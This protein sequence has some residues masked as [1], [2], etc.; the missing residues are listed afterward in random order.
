MSLNLSFDLDE[1]RAAAINESPRGKVLVI[2]AMLDEMLAEIL[3]QH[4]IGDMKDLLD[5]R[6]PFGSFGNK[7]SV[8]YAIGLIDEHTKTALKLI[9]NI[10]NDAAH[11]EKK[12]GRGFDVLFDVTATEQRVQ[13]LAE[14]FGFKLDSGNPLFAFE[15][16]GFEIINRIDAAIEISKTSRQLV[17]E[18][19][20]TVSEFLNES[21][22]NDR[23]HSAWLEI[24][25]T[26][27]P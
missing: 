27:I 23:F 24:G 26:K 10:R 18:K 17:K 5:F 4:C 20:F 12:K 14:C 16:A 15:I 2:A 13:R 7:I 19:I 22:E 11:Y 1:Y 3:T 6:G 9:Q 8:C 25:C 21:G